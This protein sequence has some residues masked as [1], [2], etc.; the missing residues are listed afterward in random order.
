MVIATT[1]KY[2]GEISDMLVNEHGIDRK[3]ITSIDDYAFSYLCQTFSIALDI[4]GFGSPFL[5][6]DAVTTH[7]ILKAVQDHLVIDYELILQKTYSKFI[8]CGDVVIDIGAHSGFHTT[9]FSRLVGNSGKLFAF[10]PLPGKYV[11]LSEKFIKDNMHIINYAL[12]DFE[13][14]ID[15]YEFPKLSELSGIKVRNTYK[16]DTEF[17]TDVNII[18]VRCA[19]LDS[20]IDHFNRIDYIKID[21]EGAEISIITGGQKAIDMFR[22]II[23]VEYGY[24]SYSYYSLTKNSLFELCEKIGYFITDIFGNIIPTLELWRELC[25]TVYWDYFLVPKEKIKYFWTQVHDKR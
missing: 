2:F 6:M 23:S 8:K 21:C 25:D 4:C 1:Y 13:G 14:E 18:K 24:G 7:S 3:T 22:P 12:S 16:F 20:F 19:K 11:E 17:Q 10:E 5:Y 9:H 15:F